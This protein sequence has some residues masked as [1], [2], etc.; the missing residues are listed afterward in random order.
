[1]A[2]PSHA[3]ITAALLYPNYWWG[4][5]VVTYSA[6]G[7]GAYWGG[8]PSQ[9]P[10]DARYAGLSELQVSRLD[11]AMEAWDRLIAIDL[12]RVVQGGD[13]QVAF[14]D[15]DAIHG[16][17]VWGYA[18]S[19]PAYGGYGS[20]R[21]GDIWI[22]YLRTT[23]PF[24]PLTI[25]HMNLLHEVGH[26]LG[27]SH[28][29]DH[30]AALPGAY[31]RHTFTVMSYDPPDERL[32]VR[33]TPQAS[34]NIRIGFEG[35]YPTTPMV[36]DILALQARYGADL[37]TAAGDDVYRW[38][39]SRPIF[40]TIY[41][42]GGVDT[43]D[44]SAHLRS[45]DIDL[46]P[47]VYSTVAYYSAAQQAADWAAIYPQNEGALILNFGRDDIFQWRD[48]LGI[49]HGTMIENVLGGAGADTVAGNA[50]D[51]R[52]FGGSGDDSLTGGGGQD[53]LRGEAGDDIVR[54]GDAFDDVHG[55]MGDDTVYG[56][57]GGDWVVGGKDQDHLHGEAG[58]DIVYG[59]MGRD[60]QWGGPGADL[61][62]GGQDADVVYG[63]AGDDWLSGDRG[64]DSLYG[65]SGADIFHSFGEAGIDW[66]GDFSRAEGDRIQLDPGT[67]WTLAFNASGAAISMSGGGLL[68]LAGVTQE[69]LGDGWLVG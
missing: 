56:G 31:D 41:D 30:G 26:A 25:D 24:E 32:W 9:E 39:E 52:V 14:T 62:R 51:N 8:Y 42:A 19:P 5:G 3:Q 47:G 36:F 17:N 57:A 66:V 12:V 65:G 13:I 49:A 21:S 29:F 61:M 43:L 28:P 33:V 27:L 34:G 2:E 11:A 15:V 10:F 53:Y 7:A 60:T 67:V 38:E 44:L 68:L 6:P 23:S 54:G 35:V 50:A 1:M 22:D 46:E 20:A 69:M 37:A 63:E 58:D 18:F 48:N 64:D 55:N 59:N 16:K 45:S 40:E 4:G